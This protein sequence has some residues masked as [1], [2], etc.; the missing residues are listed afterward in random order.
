MFMVVFD[1][2]GVLVK[3]EYLLEL[4]KLVGKTSEVERLT[5]DGLEGRIGWNEALNRRLELLKGVTCQQCV[6]TAKTMELYP[7]AKEFIEALRKLGNV[8][9]GI[10]TGCFDIIVN[11]IK[12]QL[13]LDFAVSNRLMFKDNELAGVDLIVDANKDL[14]MECIARR[15]GVEMD[16]VIAIGDGANDANMVSKAGLGIG[17]NPASVLQKYAKTTVCAKRLDEAL[18]IV[19]AV[20]YT[21][22]TLPTNREV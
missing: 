5:R 11:P 4:A 18:P 21:H 3:G 7:G 2:E 6:E 16:N 22:L 15:Y 1:F 19:K 10:I 20:S 12:E 17:F 9:L 8:R 14:H 13:K